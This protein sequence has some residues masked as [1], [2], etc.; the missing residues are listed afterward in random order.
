[1]SPGG[2]Y[3]NWMYMKYWLELYSQCIYMIDVELEEMALSVMTFLVQVGL[4]QCSI[5]RST[6]LLYTDDLPLVSEL[7]V[8]LHEILKAWNQMGVKG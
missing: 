7:F 4:H 2:L 3:G 5:L 6:E 8:Y 1:M